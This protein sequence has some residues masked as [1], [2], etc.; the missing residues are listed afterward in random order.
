MGGFE[1]SSHRNSQ[2]RRLDLIEATRHDEF[3]EADYARMAEI[4]M[5]TARD[6]V[7]WHLIE[8]EPYRYDFSSLANQVAAAKSTGV[9]VIWDYFH[10]GYPD[11]IDI[12]SGEFIERFARFCCSDDRVSAGRTW[13]R[14]HPLPR[15]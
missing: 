6:G 8:T 3:A 7:R 12:F 10:Y 15:Q 11:D 14:T 4:G 2:G 13:P 1:C 9:Q 5:R